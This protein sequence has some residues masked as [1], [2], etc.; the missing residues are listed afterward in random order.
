MGRWALHHVVTDGLGGLAILRRLADGADPGP[1][2]VFPRPRPS[3]RRLAGDAARTRLAGLAR[4]AGTCRELRRAVAAAGGLRAPRAVPCSI[5]APTGSRRCLAVV[6][7]DLASLRAAAHLQGGTVND[8][9]LTVVAGALHAVLARRGETVEEFRV[10]L[11]TA[12]A[13][14]AAGDTPGNGAAPLVVG[15]GSGGRSGRTSCSGG[16]CV[17]TGGPP[18][19][20]SLVA[21]DRAEGRVMVGDGPDRGAYCARDLH[22]SMIQRLFG[23]GLALQSTLACIADPAARERVIQSVTVLDEIINEIRSVLHTGQ[24]CGAAARGPDVPD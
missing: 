4:F 19:P 5:V 3:W 10:A 17:A 2:G 23:A 20:A 6:R 9:V 12:G 21:T 8:L 1:V 16:H 24:A 14:T 11:M 7:T 18:A 13:R 22:D 15:V